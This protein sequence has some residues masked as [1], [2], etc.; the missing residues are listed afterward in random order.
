MIDGLLKNI[1]IKDTPNNIAEDPNENNQD[2]DNSIS[3]S[4]KESVKH[5]SQSESLVVNVKM[6]QDENSDVNVK[7]NINDRSS[8]EF[9]KQ[10]DNS[11]QSKSNSAISQ[12]N[13]EQ[14]SESANSDEEEEEKQ[15][16]Q[17]EEIKQSN[18]E[19]IEEF[20]R[21]L[22]ENHGPNN[23]WEDPDFGA[24]R[25]LFSKPGEVGDN[26][27]KEDLTITF[28]RIT[29]DD[30][31]VDFFCFEN[32]SHNI[33]YEFK[34]KRGIIHDRFFL[35]AFLVLF[36]RNEEY[37]Q[38]LILDYEHIKENINAGFVGFT[39]FINGEWRNITVDTRV[40]KH[41]DD[42]I[43][44]SNTETQNAYWMCL[45]EKAYAKAF[46]TYDIIH[47]ILVND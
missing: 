38:N 18:Y 15:S 24:D 4:E 28:D 39:F 21:V 20:Y 25:N 17:Y 30:D 46:K 40:P 12:S 6:N 14:N 8:K 36:R 7:I 37:F 31:K 26:I 32:T 33:D 47:G 5:Q 35:G 16:I 10:E 3:K 43:T 2:N 41:Q 34:I 9:T 27:I 11:H 29:I 42:E 1:V 22:R 23:Q 13:E 44:L 19:D 45:F